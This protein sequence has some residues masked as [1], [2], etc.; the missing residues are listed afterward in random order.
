MGGEFRMDDYIAES[1][2]ENREPEFVSAR[3]VV[4]AM[5]R[6][7]AAREQSDRPHTNAEESR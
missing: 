4:D 6:E 2:G 7:Q 5:R 1:A 3:S